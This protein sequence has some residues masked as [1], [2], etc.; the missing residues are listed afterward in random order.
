MLHNKKISRAFLGNLNNHVKPIIVDIWQNCFFFF[1]SIFCLQHDW[2]N[3]NARPKYSV[4]TPHMNTVVCS[5]WKAI[6][7]CTISSPNR[8]RSL[9]LRILRLIRRQVSEW[10]MNIQWGRTKFFMNIQSEHKNARW[11]SWRLQMHIEK[12]EP[13][14]GSNSPVQWNDTPNKPNKT[15]TSAFRW[16]NP[17]NGLDHNNNSLKKKNSLYF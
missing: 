7:V 16:K 4:E 2:T 8:S 17:L 1:T 5:S 15:P 12:Y 6:M 13:P 11:L 10:Q 14:G 9:S 3:L